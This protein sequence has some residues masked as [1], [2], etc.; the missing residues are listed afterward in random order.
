MHRFFF[1]LAYGKHCVKNNPP[2]LRMEGTIHAGPA[3]GFSVN[4]SLDRR[5]IAQCYFLCGLLFFFFFPVFFSFFFFSSWLCSKSR[6][7]RISGLALLRLFLTQNNSSCFPALSLNQSAFHES[8][9]LLGCVER[10]EVQKM[11]PNA[12]PERMTLQQA[13]WDMLTINSGQPKRG[14]GEI[15]KKISSSCSK[16]HFKRKTKHC[17]HSFSLLDCSSLSF[18]ISLQCWLLLAAPQ[19]LSPRRQ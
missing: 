9:W 17:C 8:C 2:A 7:W 3:V 15:K 16:I 12:L 10:R 14:E 5:T 6:S 11:D 4:R 1:F 13:S 18:P 19:Q